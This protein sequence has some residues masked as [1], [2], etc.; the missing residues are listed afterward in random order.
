MRA[1]IFAN[2]ELS[3]PEAALAALKPDDRLIAA[4]GGMRHVRALG[5]TPG[6]MI[7]DLDSLSAADLEAAE[8]GGVEISRYSE[9]KDQT[10][11]ELAMHHAVKLGAEEIVVFGAFGTRWDHTLANLL[12]SLH[13]GMRG[14]QCSF[15]DAGQR[16]FPAQGLTRI[17]GIPGDVVSLIP[18]GGEAVGVTTSGLEYPLRDGKLSLGSTLG[19]SNVLVRSP[20]TIEVRQ[21]QLLVI[22]SHDRNDGGGR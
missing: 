4:D 6:W 5:L 10:D 13:P 15:V 2:G 8:S 9:R 12:L 22:V 18:V 14:V 19:V 20:A 11:L 7:G 1:V 17:D 21:G 16:I 3:N